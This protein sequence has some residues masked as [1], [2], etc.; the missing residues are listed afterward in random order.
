MQAV[1]SPNVMNVIGPA[2]SVTAA[3]RGHEV[4]DATN[5]LHVAAVAHV[6]DWRSRHHTQADSDFAFA[7]ATYEEA[8]GTGGHHLAA[9]WVA[10]R[11]TQMEKLLPEAAVVV[12]S[13]V[14]SKHA[15]SFTTPKAT[16]E[17]MGNM[18]K[19]R[20]V[21]LYPNPQRDTRSYYAQSG[22]LGRTDDAFWS[23]AAGWKDDNTSGRRMGP[24]LQTPIPEVVD[25]E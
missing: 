19:R 14:P 10:I 18:S 8:V 5:A 2:I 1:S 22:S 9:E 12:E 25:G 7:F 24:G 23:A 4:V 15:W 16:C 11:A 21:R 3:M 13:Q 20:G 6:K 17:A